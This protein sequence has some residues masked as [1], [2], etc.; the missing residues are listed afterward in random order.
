MDENNLA[1][2][3]LACVRLDDYLRAHL[4]QDREHLLR[5]N[6][7]LIDEAKLLQKQ[8]V[9]STPLDV[10]MNL[11]TKR[12]EDWFSR[13]ADDSHEADARMAARGRAL[14]FTNDLYRRFP[15]AFLEPEP[16]AGLR[17]AVRSVTL[18][19]GPDIELASLTRKE[20]DYGPMEDIVGE[21]WHQFAWGYVL[22]AFVIWVIIFFAAYGS[23]LAFVQS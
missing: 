18:Q 6:L 19:T 2:W 13:L 10:T 17:D 16:P 9:D 11:V 12:T 15:S 20:I 8:H 21:T 7:Q 23:Y 22:R 3:N 4:V 1:A 14:W 5:L